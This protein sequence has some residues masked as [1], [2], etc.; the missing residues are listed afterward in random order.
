MAPSIEGEAIENA[1]RVPVRLVATIRSTKVKPVRFVFG[2]LNGPRSAA[3][4][5]R[6]MDVYDSH[7]RDDVIPWRSAIEVTPTANLPL[8]PT[9]D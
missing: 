9:I 2:G 5:P 3:G 4:A 7:E 1:A 8:A 6:S